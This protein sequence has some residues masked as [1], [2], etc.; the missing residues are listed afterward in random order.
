MARPF[1]FALFV[2]A[3]EKLPPRGKVIPSPAPSSP[4]HAKQPP[5]GPPDLSA[6]PSTA[7]LVLLA[8]VASVSCVITMHLHSAYQPTTAAFLPYATAKAAGQAIQAART[9]FQ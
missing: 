9:A 3:S 7:Y 8:L 6:Y 2:R 5:T 4:I 1:L